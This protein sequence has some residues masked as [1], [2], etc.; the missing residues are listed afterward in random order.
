MSSR[1]TALIQALRDADKP[2]AW[3][4]KPT[5]TGGLLRVS[6]SVGLVRGTLAG[7]GYTV[8]VVGDEADWHILRVGR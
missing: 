1:T 7:A 4:L 5:D 8:D 3:H 2:E 6:D